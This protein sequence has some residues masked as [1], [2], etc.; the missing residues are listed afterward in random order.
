MPSA[1]KIV[2]TLKELVDVA[3]SSPSSGQALVYNSTTQKWEN[4]NVSGTGDGSSGFSGYSSRSGFSGYSSTS[5]FSGYSSTSGFSGYSSTS[6]LSGFSGYSAAS[7]FSGYSGRSGAGGAPGP[8]GFPGGDSLYIFYNDNHAGVDPGEGYFTSD[9]GD[10]T[11]TS[12]L[13]FSY[14]DGL[15]TNVIDWVRALDDSTNSIKGVLRFYTIGDYT[16][17]VDFYITGVLTDHTTYATLQVGFSSGTLAS[18]PPAETEMIVSFVRIGDSGRSGYSGYSGKSGFSG[19]SGAGGSGF[20]GYSGAGTSGFS[21]YS[22]NGSS[23]FSGYSGA[24]GSGFSGYSGA[25]GSGFSG[26]SGTGISGFSGYSGGGI[27]GFSGYS[28]I[29]SSG[30][31]GYSGTGGSGFSG[32]S[33]A[34][35]SGF[36]GYSGAGG[37]GFSG[38][39]GNG[40]SG[41]SGYSSVGVSGFSGY[42]GQSG[43]SGYSGRSGFSGYSSIS[44]FSGYSAASG[45]SGYSGKSGYSGYSGLSGFSGMSSSTT[46]AYG[47][48]LYTG[49]GVSG[50]TYDGSGDWDVIDGLGAGSS[51][52]TTLSTSSITANSSGAFLVTC[53]LSFRATS[54]ED[55]YIFAIFKN[56]SVT[57]ISTRNWTEYNN[58]ATSYFS[59]SL[60]GILVLAA[61]DYIEVRAKNLTDTDN[62]NLWRAN[63][64]LSAI[65]SSSD[66]SLS[67]L[68]F[69]G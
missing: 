54:E 17:Y 5:G 3:V 56:G 35:G 60:T 63:F 61:D 49:D 14:T 16:Q 44:G 18:A 69:M 42:S 23:G 58:G 38:Y 34:G 32:Y 30:F 31:S 29:S 39:S 66:S 20:S 11:S 24:G 67:A 9:D 64:A 22:G 7:G 10:F 62:I 48:I 68:W 12:A 21:G 47:E 57:N 41:F 45:F 8:Q 40:I 51:S 4:A 37:S 52:S 46:P 28:S 50:W 2:R 53:S 15:G 36:S 59:V 19:Y 1:V 13:N 6:G 43:F 26:Y 27:S 55:S 65:G 25:G 33:G